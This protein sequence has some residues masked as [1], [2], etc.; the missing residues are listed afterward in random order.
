M[1][2]PSRRRRPRT[3]IGKILRAWPWIRFGLR[4]MRFALRVRRAAI[5]AVISFHPAPLFAAIRRRRHGR[6]QGASV[7]PA[8]SSGWGG[9]TRESG[10]SA[11]PE[12]QTERRLEG[13]KQDAPENA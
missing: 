10:Y 13:V 8:P 11:G 7:P 9:G 5:A 2:L 12:T 4:L 6:H 3:T 1:K